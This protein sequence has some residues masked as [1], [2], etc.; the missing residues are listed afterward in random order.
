[1]VQI[2]PLTAGGTS[3]QPGGESCIMLESGPICSL[4][5]KLLQH[6]SLAVREVRTACG[7]CCKR[8]CEWVCANFAVMCR[9]IRKIVA[10]YLNLVGLLSI[11]LRKNLA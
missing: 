8:G 10:I 5:A 9:G 1:M 7:E 3:S 2:S 4:V 6:L 11:S